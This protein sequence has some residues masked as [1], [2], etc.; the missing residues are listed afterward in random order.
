MANTV[1]PYSS[2][3]I[4]ATLFLQYLLDNAQVRFVFGLALFKAFGPCRQLRKT[5]LHGCLQRFLVL[6]QI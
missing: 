6:P 3:E 1:V 4:L 2:F 5:G